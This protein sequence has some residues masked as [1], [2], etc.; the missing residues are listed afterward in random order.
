MLSERGGDTDIEGA[1][2]AQAKALVAQLEGG[3]STGAMETINEL[4]QKRDYGLYQEIGKLTRNIHN[5]IRDFEIDITVPSTEEEPMGRKCDASD[6]LNY[7]IQL[8]ENAANKT[9]DMVEDTI[10]ISKELGDT[11]TKL[12]G[13][14]QRL[15]RRELSGEEFRNLYKEMDGFLEFTANKASSIDSN[16][17]SILLAQD[18]QDLTGQVIKRVI[19]LVTEVQINLVT[20]VKTASNVEMITGISHDLP[21][22]ILEKDIEAE[23]PTVNAEARDDVVN[24]QD[25][26]DDLLSSLGF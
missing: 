13:D 23:G 26:V 16:L 12:K 20:M 15:I 4:Y 2:V 21:D 24:N 19:S 17:S 6:R 7:V 9:M 25:E 5:A 3:D 1:L 14:W 8:T 10:P 18:Y 11:A 22:D